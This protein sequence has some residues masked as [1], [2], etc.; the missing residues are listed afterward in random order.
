MTPS[1]LFKLQIVITGIPKST[2]FSR[3]EGIKGS[4]KI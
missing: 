2:I 1:I 3:N 4:Q